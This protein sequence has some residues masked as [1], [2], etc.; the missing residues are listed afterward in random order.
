MY[1]TLGFAILATLV[2]GCFSSSVWEETK[3]AARYIQRA[4]QSIV[5]QAKE[6]RLVSNEWEF[7]SG[8]SEEEYI[9][10]EETDVR[11]GAEQLRQSEKGHVQAKPISTSYGR[12]VP[13][14]ADFKTPSAQLS[15]IFS[16]VYFHT[17]AHAFEESI[18]LDTIR[19]ISTYLKRNPS[20]YLS[21]AGHTDQRASESYN[22]ALGTRRANFV[23]HLLIK[24]GIDPARLF[25]VSYGKEFL[26]DSSN[27]KEAWSKNRRVEFKIYEHKV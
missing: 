11:S 21:I 3:T 16:S 12:V 19:K 23:R 7:Y 8:E 25:T 17:D 10:L 14:L 4:G 24:E 15:S 9:A 26:A 27:T 1:K 13:T 22:L 5:G 20:C 2:T 18:Y 6:S